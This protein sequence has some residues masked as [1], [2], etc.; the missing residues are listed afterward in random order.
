MNHLFADIVQVAGILHILQG[1]LNAEGRREKLMNF[2]HAEIVPAFKLDFGGAA[3]STVSAVLTTEHEVALAWI[4]GVFL[5]NKQVNL[6][7]FES[8]NSF[9]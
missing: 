9:L 8:S 3:Q 1:H 5:G 2:F 7:H 4:G 6:I